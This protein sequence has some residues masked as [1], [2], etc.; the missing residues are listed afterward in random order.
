MVTPID[1]TGTGRLAPF[2]VPELVD[3]LNYGTGY[4]G[5]GRLGYQYYYRPPGISNWSTD[6][7]D[8][9]NLATNSLNVLHGYESQRNPGG[10]NR[11]IMA[12][13]PADVFID[14][15]TSNPKP[16]SLS[17]P[18]MSGSVNSNDPFLNPMTGVV[19][20]TKTLGMY[21]RRQHGLA[22]RPRS[23]TSYNE[24]RNYDAPFGT[25]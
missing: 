3:P 2:D 8:P 6:H 25:R 17:I 4:D 24:D 22:A 11:S 12:A 20:L 13:M 5:K 15:V 19:D 7:V 1:L 23:L 14:P 16:V 21:R 10:A 18:T 9:T